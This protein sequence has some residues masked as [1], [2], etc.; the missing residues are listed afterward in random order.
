MT[1][2]TGIHFF[3]LWDTGLIKMLNLIALV[4]ISLTYYLNIIDKTSASAVNIAKF[5]NLQQKSMYIYVIFKAFFGIIHACH[6]IQLV[7]Q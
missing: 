6:F 5:T 7:Y 3:R 1:T 2:C 4:D